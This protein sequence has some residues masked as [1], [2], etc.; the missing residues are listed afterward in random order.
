CGFEQMKEDRRRDVVGQVA[1]DSQLRAVSG[2]RQ[3]SEV[4]AED[5]AFDDG[6]PGRATQTRREITID[7]DDGQRAGTLDERCRE[8]TAPGADLD[9]RIART[10]I[11][12]AD[13]PLDDRR[14]DEE[15]LA[16][17]LPRVRHSQAS[18]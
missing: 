11:D 10:R 18:L 9:E 1:D 14:L 16:E 7:L 4:D 15:V 3:S 17:A 12:L 13:D 5:V 8:R 2:A 6:E